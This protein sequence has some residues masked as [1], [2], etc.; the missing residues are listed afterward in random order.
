[1]AR[2]CVYL[3]TTLWLA[4]FTA[5]QGFAAFKEQESSVKA[6]ALAHFIMGANAEFN[7]QP[8]LA[9][10]EYRQAVKLSPL[11]TPPRLKLAAYLIRFDALDEAINQLQAVTA[12][13]PA[14][15]HAH[16]LL[17]LVYSAQKKYD[18]AAKEY[19]TVLKDATLKNPLSI[20][21]HAYLAQLYFAQHKMD[22]AIVQFQEILLIDPNHVVANYLLG[23]IFLDQNKLD[24]AVMHLQKALEGNPDHDGALNAL[25]YT[26]A[27]Q[28]VQLENAKKM[29]LH[30]IDLDK[31]NGAYYDTYG[32]VLFKLQAY[33]ESLMALQKAESLVQDPI[34]YDHLG[35]VYH[36]LNQ[37]ALARKAWIKS[38]Q[39][40]NN[41]DKVRQKL[42]G[43]D[44]MQ[45]QQIS[46][47]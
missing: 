43:L 23:S 19:E 35:D 24:K 20:E 12:L 15:F 2:C 41:Q 1:M 42:E 11:E 46:P 28:G 36:K 16:Y 4:V 33:P 45:A 47:R 8:R 5:D 22:E 30:A 29:I 40:D 44:K 25:A 18:L 10:E 34:I 17:A 21:V 39:Y 31:T 32:W 26:Y 13:E 7:S 38:L 37:L 27:Q 6:E 3:M 9:Q 14:N